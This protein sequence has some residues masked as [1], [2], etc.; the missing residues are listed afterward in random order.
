M[1]MAGTAASRCRTASS[2][3][4]PMLTVGVLLNVG[5]TRT[6]YFRALRLVYSLIFDS[7][8]LTVGGP[9]RWA[10]PE[11]TS[12]TKGADYLSDAE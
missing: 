2:D 3:E 7:D 10:R 6:N 1:R 9:F 4:L 8:I 12:S 5:F 11:H